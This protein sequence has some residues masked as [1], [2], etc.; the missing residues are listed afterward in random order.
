MKAER[1]PAHA[2]QGAPPRKGPEEPPAGAGGG[3]KMLLSYFQ[4]S[5]QRL[6]TDD[7]GLPK[8]P[9][10]SGES[11]PPEGWLVCKSHAAQEA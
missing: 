3:V 6:V 4:K 2:G 5:K 10:A 11:G 9:Q 1:T 8:G 7:S